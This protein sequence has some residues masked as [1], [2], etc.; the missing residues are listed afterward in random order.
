MSCLTGILWGGAPTGTISNVSLRKVSLLLNTLDV[1]VNYAELEDVDRVYIPLS[2]FALSEYDNILKLISNRFDTYIYM[3]TILKSN[4]RNLFTTHIDRALEEFRIKGF[5]V[6]NLGTLYMLEPYINNYELIG[7][8]TLNV[9]NSTSAYAYRDLG[10][11][12]IT[13]SPELNKEHIANI[14]ST[15]DFTE[16]IV[17][18]KTPVMTL[19]YCVLGKSNKCYPNC[20]ALCKSKNDYYLKD[21][22]G[23]YFRVV[24]DNVQ[25][26]NTIYNSKITSLDYSGLP[27][28]SVRIDILDENILEINHIIQTVKQEKRLEGKDYTSANF[29]REV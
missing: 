9:L 26:I 2:Y 6:S 15:C 27:V 28:N 10:L 22:L 17:Y 13:L 4:Y 12:N 1:N 8:Y 20:K 14:A 25:T 24:A 23:L 3:P 21:R 18:G 11:S 29:I 7:N 19:G 5:V 16:L